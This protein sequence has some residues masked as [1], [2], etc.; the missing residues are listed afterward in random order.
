[1]SKGRRARGTLYD[2]RLQEKCSW[3]YR[4]TGTYWW[5]AFAG[6]TK[7]LRWS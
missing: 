3:L 2:I 6:F 4:D 5:K 1:V 7:K